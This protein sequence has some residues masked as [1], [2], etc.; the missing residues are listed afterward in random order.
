MPGDPHPRAAHRAPPD[1]GPG[2]LTPQNLI[3]QAQ[4]GQARARHAIVR[5]VLA[6]HTTTGRTAHPAVTGDLV[7]ALDVTAAPYAGLPSPARVYGLRTRRTGRAPQRTLQS[8]MSG[9]AAAIVASVIGLT[10]FF[11]IA[12]TRRGPSTESAAGP[13]VATVGIGSP[14]ADA[15]P[16]TRSDVFPHRTIQPAGAAPYRVTTTRSDRNCRLGTTGE[17]GA[18]LADHGCDQVVR[19]GLTAPD[20][21]YQVTAGIF[22]FTDADGAA[23]VSE[24]TGPL[25]EAGQGSFAMLGGLPGDPLAAPPVQ[26]G[27]DQRGPHLLYCVI[28]RP[29]GQ[30]VAD[31][32]PYAGQIVTDLVEQYLGEQVIGSRTQ[33]P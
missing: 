21:G 4:A 9:L 32:D 1:G 24:L 29:D 17:L 3:R 12:E 5:Q 7:A 23:R 31:D 8:L 11:V 22:T 30:L 33:S 6:Q 27:W 2:R 15:E 16:L 19:A 18:L 25:V 10:A 20:S 28:A 14:V 26:V 13:S